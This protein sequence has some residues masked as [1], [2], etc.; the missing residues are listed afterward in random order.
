MGFFRQCTIIIITF[1]VMMAMAAYI[2]Y[3]EWN[4]LEY[5]VLKNSDLV[6]ICKMLE[7]TCPGTMAIIRKDSTETLWAAYERNNHT[8]CLPNN[9]KIVETIDMRKQIMYVDVEYMNE[10][11]GCVEDTS[12]MECYTRFAIQNPVSIVTN[13]GVRKNS[14]STTFLCDDNVKIK[15]ITE[16]RH[17]ASFIDK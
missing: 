2:A 16:L 9:Y 1:M 17:V 12:R 13:N 5:Y 3:K 11:I 7:T 6:E 10:G 14:L 8:M 15:V 4:G